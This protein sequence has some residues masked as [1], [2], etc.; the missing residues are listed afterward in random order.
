MPG[1]DGTGKLFANFLKALDLGVRAS[2]VTYPPDVPLGYDELEARVRAAL[3][4]RGPFVLLGE[5]FSGPI[6]IRIAA[7]P[8]PGLRGLILSVTFAS[9][10]FPRLAWARRLAAYLPLKS[11]PRWIRAPLMWGSASPS[12]AP[13]QSERAMAGVAKA[14]VRRRIAELLAVDET[15]AL[16]EIAVPTLVLSAARDR[17]VSKAA[18]ER[19]LRGLRH[20]QQ[21][22][23]DGPHLLLQTCAAEC[24][25][26]VLGF[27]GGI[28]TDA[29]PI[30]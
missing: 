13:R 20:A 24:A 29:G 8:P 15:A 7:R 25:V 18:T 14:V 16:R 11:F 22:E 21:V 6:A 10:P 12:N 17:V 28:T 2:V 23:I 27:M 1:L 4:S 5:S 26:A 3:P 19:L 9:N 30:S